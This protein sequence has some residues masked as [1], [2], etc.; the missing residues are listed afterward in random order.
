MKFNPDDHNY[1]EK[2]IND[3]NFRTST[4]IKD[5][6]TLQPYNQVNVVFNV[7]TGQAS[8]SMMIKTDDINNLIELLQLTLDNI[9]SAELELIALQTKVA[10]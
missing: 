8:T 7:S 2:K 9:K 3:V 5:H 4:W 6:R 1:V 10:A